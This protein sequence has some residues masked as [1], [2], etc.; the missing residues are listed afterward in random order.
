MS[1]DWKAAK[2]QYAQQQEEDKKRVKDNL[3]FEDALKST[4]A[5]VG[6]KKFFRK[7]YW[8]LLQLA[9]AGTD[10]V[11]TIPYLVWMLKTDIAEKK[12][13]GY[14]SAY[15]EFILDNLM[16]ELNKPDESGK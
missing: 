4:L 11:M 7:P 13:G 9:I 15:C 6:N 16:K 14:T 10:D 8:D 5:G 1:I 12:K 2:E 3:N